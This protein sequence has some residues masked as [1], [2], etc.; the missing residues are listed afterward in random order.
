MLACPRGAYPL[1]PMFL[2]KPNDTST[3][4]VDSSPQL[5]NAWLPAKAPLRKE[6]LRAEKIQSNLQRHR[7]R[8]LSCVPRQTRRIPVDAQL[9][10]AARAQFVFQPNPATR[11]ATDTSRLRSVTRFGRP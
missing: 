6:Q 11:L 10:P 3:T 5:H 7:L 9:L 8:L 4:S 1:N 2:L